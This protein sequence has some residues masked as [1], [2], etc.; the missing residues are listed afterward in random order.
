MKT[1]KRA[2]QSVEQYLNTLGHKAEEFY[3]EDNEHFNKQYH[4]LVAKEY[5]KWLKEF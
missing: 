1:L 4:E 5:L 3:L 2:G